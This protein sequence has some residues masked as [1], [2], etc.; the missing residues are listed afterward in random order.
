MIM[1]IY[2]QFANDI[3]GIWVLG[4]EF[5]QA[6]SSFVGEIEIHVTGNFLKLI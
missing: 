4:D 5:W 3:N 2:Q 1:I 6:G